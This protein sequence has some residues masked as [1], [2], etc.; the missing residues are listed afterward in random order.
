L[1]ILGAQV[2]FGFQFQAVF[3]D[4]FQGVSWHGKLAQCS[5]LMLLLITV[6]LLIT[7]SLLHQLAY[8]GESRRAML[9]A[10][11]CL[12]G[13]SLLPLTLG[14][15]SSIFI[16]FEH[17][18]GGA[19]GIITGAAFTA[20]SLFLLYGLG[21]AL[22][23]GG[24]RMPDEERETP[25]KT[26]IEQLLTEARVIIPGGQALLGFQLVATLTR[27]F[28]KL[29]DSAKYIHAVA[30]CAV[31]FAVTL[32]MTPAALHR[33]AFHGED[34]ETFFRIGS[35]LVIAAACP[36][37]LGISAEVYVVFFEVSDSMRISALA[38]LLSLL[39]LLG[40][41]FAYPVWRRL[42]QSPSLLNNQG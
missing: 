35:G 19:I 20:L 15:G 36:L 6:G 42:A 25:L 28:V 30:L 11:T 39:V 8:R 7:P 38:A 10:A 12:A 5:A 32:L 31:M 27:P 24:R 40:L 26:K 22:R 34:D 37:A 3:Q 18:F 29:P 4:L 2:L 23:S 21:L 17:L 14:L 16:V 41:W 9:A 1:L 13:I 33:I